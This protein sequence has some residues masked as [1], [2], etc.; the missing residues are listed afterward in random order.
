M[1]EFRRVT[2]HFGT[3]PVL[4]DCSFK[5]SEGATF[6]LL[7]LSGSGKTT[8]L[9]MMCGLLIPDSGEVLLQGS[10]VAPDR[11]REMR[12]K[13]GYVIQ[14]G[15]LFP[16]LTSAENLRLVGREAGWDRVR[17]ENRIEELAM[18]T[19]LPDGALDRYPRQISGGQRQRVGLMRALFRDPPLLLL[20][21]PMGA[22]DPITRSEL[23]T[24]LKELFQRLRKTVILVTHDLHEAGFLSERMLL[25]DKGKVIQE[26]ALEDLVKRPE[27]AFVRR[28]VHSQHVTGGLS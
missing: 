22:L 15:G 9:K 25:L 3:T 7:G 14:D 2:K 12:S 10:P 28:F 5:V 6:A 13:L 4:E 1:I 19:R 21:E 27:N 8:A 20:D 11:W 18:L 17:V 24:E 16:H 26:G 23:Q